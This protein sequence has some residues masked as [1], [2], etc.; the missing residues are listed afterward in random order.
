M[1]GMEGRE[2]KDL[3]EP[4]EDHH[5]A[6][7]VYYLILAYHEK[8]ASLLAGYNSFPFHNGKHI[9]RACNRHH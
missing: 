6:R 3:I 4:L 1:Q 2:G 8:W 5:R 9:F 7:R